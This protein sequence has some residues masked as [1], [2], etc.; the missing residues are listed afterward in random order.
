[1]YFV[2]STD[3]YDIGSVPRVT[4]NPPTAEGVLIVHNPLF[5]PRVWN[6]SIPRVPN[7]AHPTSANLQLVNPALTPPPATISNECWKWDASTGTHTRPYWDAQLNADYQPNSFAHEQTGAYAGPKR[8]RNMTGNATLTFKGA[9]IADQINPINGNL[10]VIGAII[11]LS[12][13][14]M[15]VLGNGSARVLYSCD[16]LNQFAGLGGYRTRLGWH[17]LR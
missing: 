4:A 2:N 6:C 5:S 10:T 3:D 7:P 16:A 12:N 1:V 9:V 8:P 14:S 17:R 13:V 15:Q 11:S